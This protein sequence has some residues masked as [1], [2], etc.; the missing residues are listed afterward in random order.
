MDV[1][2]PVFT[3]F[4]LATLKIPSFGSKQLLKFD[5][6]QQLFGHILVNCLPI[7]LKIPLNYEAEISG[8]DKCSIVICGNGDGSDQ[9]G[10]K[11][12]QN[13]W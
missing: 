7:Q 3:L 5:E 9:T 6:R 12:Y 13:R 1:S 8:T 2:L 4:I 11:S 10:R